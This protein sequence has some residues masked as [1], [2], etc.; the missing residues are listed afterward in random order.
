MARESGNATIHGVKTL[1]IV[2]FAFLAVLAASCSS[3]RVSSDW[4]RG[5][6]FAR[7]ATFAWMPRD[8]AA[9]DPLDA[10]SLV[11]NRVTSSVERE[12][13]GK[14]LRR[15]DGPADVLVAYHSSTRDR[16]EVTTWPAWGYGWGRRAWRAPG[17]GPR[18]DVS[19]YTEGSLVVDLV[20]P[21][22]TDLLWRGIVRT[23]IDDASG[24]EERVAAAVH[25]LFES[26]PPA[27]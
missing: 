20:D 21:A 2:A 1:R 10:N 25:A 7:L 13:Q 8:P 17:W 4:D 19:Q 15:T 24:S 26:Y 3:W 5:A 14:G 11:R 16:V 27:Q 18:I 22:T 23:V 6:D 12:L 9:P